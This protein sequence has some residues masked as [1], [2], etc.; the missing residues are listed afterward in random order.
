[1]VIAAELDTSGEFISLTSALCASCE[2]SAVPLAEPAA[3]VSP[4]PDAVA[5]MNETPVAI[6]GFNGQL[7]VLLLRLLTLRY[8]PRI[9]Y[10]PLVSVTETLIDY[11]PGQNPESE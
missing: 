6:V 8:G 1:M 3:L 4:L 11:R 5:T 2:A 7:D 9:V 10:A